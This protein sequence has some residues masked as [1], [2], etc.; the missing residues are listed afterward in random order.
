MERSM[1]PTL[2]L[3]SRLA[4]FKVPRIIDFRDQLPREDTVKIF[5]RRVQEEYSTLRQTSA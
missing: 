1:F 3:A 5:K 2:Y 4:N